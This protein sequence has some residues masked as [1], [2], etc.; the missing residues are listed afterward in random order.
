M[1]HFDALKIYS[2]SVLTRIL[3]V[4]F[5]ESNSGKSWIPNWKVGFQLVEAG[6]P[7]SQ[8]EFSFASNQHLKN[9]KFRFVHHAGI[10][11]ILMDKLL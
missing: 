6:F 8:D 4:G 5:Q 9:A 3:K 1:P 11:Y 7:Y 2:C 10:M